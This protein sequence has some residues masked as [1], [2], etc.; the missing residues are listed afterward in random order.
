MTRTALWIPALA[1]T[2]AAGCA[3]V[4]LTV[5]NDRPAA[6]RDVYVHAGGV[7]YTV[8]TLD[9]G[10][11]D[12]RR[13]KVPADADIQVNF[14]DERGATAYTSSRLRLLKSDGRHLLLKLTPAGALDT[15]VLPK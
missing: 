9:P 6:V 8:Q 2:L 11:E 4:Q 14:K 5:R 12:T 7:T 15:D 3:Q 1:L 13:F 10:A